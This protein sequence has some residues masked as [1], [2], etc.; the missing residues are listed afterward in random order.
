MKWLSTFRNQKNSGFLASLEKANALATP[1]PQSCCPRML[2]LGGAPPVPPVPTNHFASHLEA[3]IHHHPQAVFL[4]HPPFRS[5]QISCLASAG[6]Y[7]SGPRLILL[8]L[9][10]ASVLATCRQFL[11]GHTEPWTCQSL[12]PLQFPWK[13]SCRQVI[14]SHYLKTRC[15]SCLLTLGIHTF[16]TFLLATKC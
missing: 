8:L 13:P 3:N 15:P 2:T 11:K 10:L 6:I 4:T 7:I 14:H 5:F 16:P 1:G 12:F 9:F